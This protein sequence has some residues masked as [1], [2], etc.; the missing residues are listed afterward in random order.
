MNEWFTEF[1]YETLQLTPATSRVVASPRD[2]DSRPTR[3]RSQAPPR[4]FELC[5]APA[6]SWTV[7]P[8]DFDPRPTPVQIQAALPRDFELR[9]TPVQSQSP[10][11]HNFERRPTP[12]RSQ[13]VIIEVKSS[14]PPDTSSSHKQH[15][16]STPPLDVTSHSPSP[17]RP[18]SPSTAEPEIPRTRKGRKSAKELT[19]RY[20]LA[21]EI[22]KKISGKKAKSAKLSYDQYGP[23]EFSTSLLWKDFCA[24]IA[25]QM[26]CTMTALDIDSFSWRSKPTG[27]VTNVRNSF[28]YE[29]MISHVQ[30]LPSDPV[31]NIYLI[32]NPP[33]ASGRQRVSYVVMLWV[34]FG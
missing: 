14:P 12:I 4:D 3:V 1:S 22:P 33:R 20:G 29:Q 21:I 2:F 16:Q 31:P 30:L 15:H 6:Q 24:A 11:P 25:S 27:N 13:P 18:R 28:G 19:V 9:P 26:K 32:M 8:H 10:P 7:P 5:P 17:A 23:W 34:H